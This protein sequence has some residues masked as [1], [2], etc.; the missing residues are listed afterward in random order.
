M[1]AWIARIEPFGGW[2]TWLDMRGAA[3]A[4]VAL[5]VAV[6]MFLIPNDRGGKLL[7][8]EAAVKVPWGILIFLQQGLRLYWHLL[9][10]DGLNLS[11]NDELCCPICIRLIPLFLERA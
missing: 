5:M 7:D 3:D 9:N 11:V 1:L 10:Q 4:T 6:T 2:S 8:W